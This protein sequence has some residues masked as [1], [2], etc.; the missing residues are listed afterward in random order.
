VVALKRAQPQLQ[1]LVAAM[2]QAVYLVPVVPVA[3]TL[4][5]AAVL[6]MSQQAPAVPVL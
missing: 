1:Q 5:V 6:V 3:P 2:D 4:A